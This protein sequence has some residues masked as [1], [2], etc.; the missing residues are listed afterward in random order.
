MDKPKYMEVRGISRVN[1]WGYRNRAWVGLWSVQTQGPMLPTICARFRAQ[2][3]DKV[4]CE[5]FIA[6]CTHVRADRHFTET[7]E[8]RGSIPCPNRAQ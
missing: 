2:T 7:R 8:W 4:G 6:I 5:A 1:V 3:R